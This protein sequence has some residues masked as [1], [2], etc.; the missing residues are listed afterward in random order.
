MCAPPA[1]TF[2]GVENMYLLQIDILDSARFY[3]GDTQSATSFGV[4]IPELEISEEALGKAVTETAQEWGVE[5]LYP[6]IESYSGVLPGVT[7]QPSVTFA[8]PP[9]G[10]VDAS[11]GAAQGMC[12]GELSR[13]GVA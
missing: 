10:D 9:P 2:H 8:F 5:R 12:C 11:G 4:C 1:S 3:T 6:S 13:Q 7:D